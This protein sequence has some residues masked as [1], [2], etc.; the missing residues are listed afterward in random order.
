M[1]ILVDD[2]WCE[3]DEKR[4]TIRD[5]YKIKDVYMFTAHLRDTVDDYF[6]DKYKRTAFDWYLEIKVHNFFYKL[7]MFK[8]NTRDTDLEENE[9]SFRLFVYRTLGRFL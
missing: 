8:S 4:I 7:G 9:S 2:F 3:V 1:E 6:K 5:S